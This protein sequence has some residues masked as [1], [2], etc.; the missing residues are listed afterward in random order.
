[1]NYRA[2]V[3]ESSVTGSFWKAWKLGWRMIFLVLSYRFGL[4]A[5]QRVRW[6][7]AAFPA[8]RARQPLQPE[9]TLPSTD[10][11]AALV[12]EVRK[13]SEGAPASTPSLDTRVSRR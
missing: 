4:Y 10:S 9:G 5:R 3:G 11:L 1:M 7:E 8:P 12:T 6:Q 2:R 13:R